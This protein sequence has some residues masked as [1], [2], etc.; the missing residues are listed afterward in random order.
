MND[1]PHTRM[2]V[3]GV[4][5][6]RPAIFPVDSELLKQRKCRTQALKELLSIPPESPKTAPGTW[7]LAYVYAAL[8]SR[9]QIKAS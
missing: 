4:T 1:P 3:F 8:R 6:R 2:H 9:L 7:R 5:P